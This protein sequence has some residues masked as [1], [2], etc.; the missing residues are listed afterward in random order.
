MNKQQKNAAP[1]QVDMDATL[2]G[3]NIGIPQNHGSEIK[4]TTVPKN[5][6][7]YVINE[8]WINDKL[9]A[10]KL[11]TEGILNSKPK[12][13]YSTDVNFVSFFNFTGQYLNINIPA[14]F[15]SNEDIKKNYCRC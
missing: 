13:I 7:R 10:E 5:L 1:I 15:I 11:P 8:R 6:V 3:L 14:K 9:I 4:T 12:T 2:V